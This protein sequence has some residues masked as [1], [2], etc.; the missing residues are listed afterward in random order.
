[1]CYNGGMYLTI[2]IGGTKTFLAVFDNSGKIIWS[3]K[4]PTEKNEFS[5]LN[6]LFTQIQ[7]IENHNFRI[8]TIAAPGIVRDNKIIKLGNLDWHNFDLARKLQERLNCPVF[9]KNDAD[10][11]TLYESKFYPKKRIIYLTFSTGIG[12]G[13]AENGELTPES[14]SFEPGHDIYNFHNEFL[15]W[16]DIASCNALK[17]A[18]HRTAVQNIYGLK[19]YIDISRRLAL[20]IVPII[21][22]QRP[23]VIIIGGPLGSIFIRF[24]RVLR[25]MVKSNLTPPLNAVKIVKAKRPQECVTYGAYLYAKQLSSKKQPTTETLTTLSPNGKQ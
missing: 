18:Y 10:L 6:K 4:V 24:K 5:F 12:G 3:Q 8:I 19:N 25:Y 21:K 9:I 20:G 1:M 22:K 15:E 17:V 7:Q 11:A 2:D 13:I 14:A 16:E 23:D